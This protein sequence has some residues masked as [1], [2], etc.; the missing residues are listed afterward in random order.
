MRDPG[1]ANMTIKAKVLIVL[2]LAVAIG[3]ALSSLFPKHI[4]GVVASAVWGS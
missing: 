2:S 1:E 4:A 3:I